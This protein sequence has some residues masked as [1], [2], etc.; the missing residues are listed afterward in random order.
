MDKMELKALGKINL[1]LDVLGKKSNSI[2]QFVR[3]R[4]LTN[5]LKSRGTCWTALA[6]TRPRLATS[7]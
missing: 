7:C 5:C 3:R 2:R 1:G 4:R 6:I